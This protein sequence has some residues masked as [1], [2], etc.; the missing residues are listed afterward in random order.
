MDGG[1]ET[2]IA[3]ATLPRTVGDSLYLRIRARGGQYDF[4]Y[5]ARANDWRPV[6]LG[7]DGTILSTHVAGGFVGTV[8]GLYVYA[9]KPG[10]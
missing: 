9:G 3:E 7:V 8:I 1:Q 4:L 5:A 2:V 6:A 10:A